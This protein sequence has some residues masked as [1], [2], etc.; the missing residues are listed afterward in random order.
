[1]FSQRMG[2]TEVIAAFLNTIHHRRLT[3]AVSCAL[4]Y[5][6]VSVDALAHSATELDVAYGEGPSEKIDFV[7]PAKELD[8]L[9]LCC[10]LCA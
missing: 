8:G 2:P 10:V 5:C 4:M 9:F 1:M 6:L 3:H 7:Y